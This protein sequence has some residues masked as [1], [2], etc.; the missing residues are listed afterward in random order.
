MEN[1]GLRTPHI[2]VQIHDLIDNKSLIKCKESSRIMC[3]IIENLKFGKFLTSRKIQCYLKKPV[4]F[5]K[6]WKIIF[7]KLPAEKLSEFGILVR[8]FYMAVP[9][10]F[11]ENWCPMHIAAERGHLDFCKFIAKVSF[12]K[13]FRCPPLLFSAQAGHLEVSKYLY[14]EIDNKTPTTGPSQITAQHLAAKNGHL[15][16]YKFLHENSNDINPIMQEDITPLHLAAL[17]G[18]FDVCKY[19]C[20][21][22]RMVSP[23]RSDSMT[24]LDLANFKG[25]YKVGDLLSERYAANNTHRI[26]RIGMFGTLGKII[27]IFLVLLLYMFIC[28]G[29]FLTLDLL[30][31]PFTGISRTF[32]ESIHSNGLTFII[33]V[34]LTPFILL[35]IDYSITYMKDKWFSF[36][37]SP[38]LDY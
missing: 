33:V 15:E 3:S 38:K 34:F 27:I 9:S 22:T 19:I 30:Q 11:E 20:D 28:I 6:D 32:N 24:P 26:I 25:H 8:D 7:Q 10:R 36:R 23:Y 31:Y 1:I 12:N 37:T 35:S 18:H 29:F 14:T 17:Y 13:S 16:I 2:F 4:E 21:N 5:G